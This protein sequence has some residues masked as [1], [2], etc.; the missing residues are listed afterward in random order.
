MSQAIGD[1]FSNIWGSMIHVNKVDY[2]DADAET[3]DSSLVVKS[4]YTVQLRKLINGPSYST[5][6]IL[7]DPMDATVTIGM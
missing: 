5:A 3:E 6:N 2:D 4:V 7:A 1:Y